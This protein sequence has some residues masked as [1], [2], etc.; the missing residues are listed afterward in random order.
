MKM[1]LPFRCYRRERWKQVRSDFVRE[2]IRICLVALMFSPSVGGTQIRA[3]KQAYHLQA[4]RHE[5]TVVTLRLDRRWKQID[6][7]NGLPIRRVGGVYKYGGQLR[8]GRLGLLAVSIAMLLLLWRLHHQYDVL[9]VFEVSPL[10]AV[11]T[12]IGKITHKPVI[13]SIQNT[14]PSD[15]QRAQIRGE[16]MLMLDTLTSTNGLRCDL[17]NVIATAGD[18]TYFPQLVLG[19]RAILNFLQKSNA[20]YQILSTRSR[21][22]LTSRGFRVER[23]VHIPT[24]VDTEKFRP[25]TEKR[26]VVVANFIP[27]IE[28]D[29]I[30]IARLEYSK[31]I[32]VLLHAWGRV[33][34]EHIEQRLSLK[35]RLRLVGKG[36]LRSQ[37]EHI[38]TELGLWDSVE[39]LGLR[40]D[41]V[42]LLQQC[43]GFVLPS[44]WEG[45][46]NALLEA[47]ACGL[48][49]VATRVSGSEDIISDGINGLLVEPEQP[50]EMASSLCRIIE[51][52][53]LAQR[54][55]LEGRETVANRYELSSVVERCLELYYNLLT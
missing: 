1:F 34:K 2:R 36:T 15:T 55:G 29:I 21:T 54:L 45:M 50:A 44:R 38:V 12:L 31:G 46:P 16:M 4:L 5:V 24:G 17:K 30:C 13:I 41:V 20:Y 43:W 47:M 32:D 6:M 7:L 14:G 33:M 51:D 42:E 9:H 19:G 28:R 26:P 49:C 37:L 27:P 23:I 48:P 22:Y 39:F 8:I 35:L 52:P 53:D 18:I 11:A 25:T 10:A 40:T 3:E